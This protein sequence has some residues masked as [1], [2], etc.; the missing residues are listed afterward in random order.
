MDRICVLMSTYN[1][2]KYLREQINSIL[3]QKDVDITLVVRDDASSDHTCE[4]LD[5]YQSKGLLTWSRGSNI[6]PAKSFI[7]LLKDNPDYDYYAFADQDD[8]WL[9]DKLF[10]AVNKLKKIDDIPKLY[11]GMARVTDEDLKWNGEHTRHYFIQRFSQAVIQSNAVG[12]TCVFDR[13]LRDIIAGKSNGYIFMHDSWI[14][15]VCL[16]VGGCLIFDEDV[17]VLYRQHSTNVIGAKRSLPKK[18]SEY[19][20][21]IKNKDCVRSRQ[22][23]TLVNE[24]ADEMEERDKELALL[25]SI[26]RSSFSYRMKLI[27]CKETKTK[28]KMLNFKFKMAVLLGVF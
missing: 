27:F 9:E 1:G 16:A 25:I 17:H 13:K 18:V 12:C 23:E 19:F 5:E 4:I 21:K 2:Q 6:G 14:H 10:I 3:S 7:S 26:Y 15:K 20:R 28:Y 22:I 24:Y 11:Y 8:C